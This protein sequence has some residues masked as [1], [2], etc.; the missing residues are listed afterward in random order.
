MT[1]FPL[2]FH[3]HGSPIMTL[4]AKALVLFVAIFHT[5]IAIVETAF[6]MHPAVHTLALKRLTTGSSLTPLVQ[7]QTLK[8]LFFNLGFYNL[9]LAIAGIAGLFLIVR[10]H[11]TAGRTLIAYMCL[12]ATGAG[13]VLLI[14]TGAAIGAALQA[15]PAAAALALMYRATTA[16]S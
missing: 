16:E 13:I 7:A 9:F 2:R 8:T 12:S 1:Q 15:V 10:G 14:S 3:W 6:W 11:L 5:S 4:I